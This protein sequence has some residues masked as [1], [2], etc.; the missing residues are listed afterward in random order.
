MKTHKVVGGPTRPLEV[1]AHGVV[2]EQEAPVLT[3]NAIKLRE[4]RVEL[5]FSIREMAD[6]LGLSPVE[7]GEIERGMRAPDDWTELWAEVGD[8]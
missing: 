7:L 8:Y 1:Y 2:R 3:E 5:R 6:K 4:R